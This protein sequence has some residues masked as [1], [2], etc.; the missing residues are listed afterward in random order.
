MNE[1][2]A[3]YALKAKH[4]QELIADAYNEGMTDKNNETAIR[5]LELPE[6]MFYAYLA[7][8]GMRGR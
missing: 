2:S 6:N 5:L 8:A 3:N 4:V 1:E 7:I